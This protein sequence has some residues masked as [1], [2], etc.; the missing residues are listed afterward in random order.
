MIDKNFKIKTPKWEDLPEMDLYLE[1]VVKVLKEYLHPFYPNKEEKVITKTMINNYVKF[2]V[3]K[4]PVNKKYSRQHIAYLFVI[5]LLKNIYSIVDIKDLIRLAI[6]VS[7]IETSY[8]KFCYTL[9]KAIY[10][11]FENKK[12]ID[13]EK[14]GKGRHLL[15]CV[16]SSIANKIYVQ[17][18]FLNK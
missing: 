2:G 13:E 8:N 16:A 15:K 10:C 1:Q 17:K 18:T 6:S 11:T 9:D 5:C 14:I 7:S 4:P 3:L 12:Y